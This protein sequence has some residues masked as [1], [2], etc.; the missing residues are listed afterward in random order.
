MVAASGKSEQTIYGKTAKATSVGA[1]AAAVV[2]YNI[3]Q[4]TQVGQTEIQYGYDLVCERTGEAEVAHPVEENPKEYHHRKRR[5]RSGPG[6]NEN[7]ESS[8]GGIYD[9]VQNMKLRKSNQFGN[10]IPLLVVSAR[11]N[12]WFDAPHFLPHYGV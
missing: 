9:D 10:V 11:P 8:H 3:L 4:E 5:P 7:Q 6:N 1:S 2:Q 12:R